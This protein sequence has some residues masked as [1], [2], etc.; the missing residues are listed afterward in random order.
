[1]TDKT[2]LLTDNLQTDEK[3]A[4]I[5]LGDHEGGCAVVDGCME[6]IQGKMLIADP[7]AISV[8]TDVSQGERWVI[9][10]YQHRD[11]CDLS[12]ADLDR[13]VQI[14]FRVSAD[15]VMRTHRIKELVAEAGGE[16]PGARVGCDPKPPS[17][18]F[19]PSGWGPWGG[20][21]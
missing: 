2:D 16:R 14:G 1:M 6:D 5:A 8:F 9:L 19:P 20:G 21:N 11:L 10:L 12:P 3:V 13:L 7:L 17:V 4:M 15:K 18:G